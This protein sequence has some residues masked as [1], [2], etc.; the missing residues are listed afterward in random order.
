MLRVYSLQIRPTFGKVEKNLKKVIE[1]LSE[2]KEGSVIFL[3]EMWQCGFDYENMKKHAQ[4]TQEV[5]EELSKHSKEKSLTLVG[6]Y[7]T[8]EGRCI[9]NTAIVIGK[10]QILGRRHKIKLFPLYQE[11]RFFCA[12]VENTVFQTHFGSLGILICFELRFTSLVLEL[13]KQ[14][15][16]MLGVPAM[17]GNKRKE[18]WQL[19]TK[20]RAVELQAYL[21]ASNAWGKVG[22]E[23]YAGCSG[24]Y[25]PW[26]SVLSY[27]E[28]GDIL[29][30]AHIELAQVKKV[31]E[32]LPVGD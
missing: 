30:S 22:E 23:D 10:G 18:H 17:W 1:L 32:S 16:Q 5:L 13:K 31:R 8:Q 2:V 11:D 24:I 3:P 9:Y 29:L 7:P 15:V 4:A 19:F 12:G 20:T 21:I 26:G 6:T 14:Q 28:K 25:D 27:A